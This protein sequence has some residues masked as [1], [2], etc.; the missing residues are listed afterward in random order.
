[1]RLLCAAQQKGRHVCHTRHDAVRVAE[2]ECR[3]EAASGTLAGVVACDRCP[4][5][6]MTVVCKLERALKPQV[7]DCAA[8]NIDVLRAAPYDE[9][10]RVYAAL[11]RRS[12]PTA[13][14]SAA[15]LRELRPSSNVTIK[16]G[17]WFWRWF[18]G[19][20]C[21]SPAQMVEYHVASI[22][23]WDPATLAPR[24]TRCAYATK[25][26]VAVTS[27]ARTFAEHLTRLGRAYDA[28]LLA[29]AILHA[30]FRVLLLPA[31]AS[32]LGALYPLHALERGAK[33]TVEDH[34]DNRRVLAVQKLGVG[35]LR[36]LLAHELAHSFFPAVWMPENHPPAFGAFERELAPFTQNVAL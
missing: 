34:A 9:W 29:S 13:E 22:A 16:R 31:G 10:A 25:V 17:L 19:A 24:D 1:M 33:A 6:F 35:K 30:G 15:G 4:G 28:K 12:P 26:R 21:V 20:P 27:L 2:S 3:A 8:R 14:L 5:R 18:Y 23:E 32:L 36:A 7:E 11:V